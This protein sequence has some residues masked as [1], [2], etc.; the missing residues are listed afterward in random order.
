[1]GKLGGTE[2]VQ[3][4]ALVLIIH[5]FATFFK[6]PLEA[7]EAKNRN[8]WTKERC[9]QTKIAKMTHVPVAWGSKSLQIN[10]ATSFRVERR[11]NPSSA[12]R[13]LAGFSARTH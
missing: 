1:M 7:H 4:K 6:G 3:G 10:S 13:A 5:I 12:T 11:K 9:E 2:M 8:K